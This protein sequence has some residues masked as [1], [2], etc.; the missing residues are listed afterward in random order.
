MTFAR[1]TPPAAL[2][3]EPRKALILIDCQNDFIDQ[4]QGKL[5][6]PGASTFVERLSDLATSFRSKGLVVF[7]QTEFRGARTSFSP[8]WGTYNILQQQHLP[9]DP[10][11]PEHGGTHRRGRSS[12]PIDPEAFLQASVPESQRACRPGTSGVALSQP[13]ADVYDPKCDLCITKSQYSAFKDTPLLLQLRMRMVQHLYVAGSLSNIGVYATVTDAVRHGLQVTLIEDCLGYRNE[14]CHVEAVKQMVDMMGASGVDQQELMD[15]LAGLLGDV[16][17]EEDLG[18]KFQ[19]NV[20]PPKPSGL[21]QPIS[22]T[23]LTPERKQQQVEEWLTDRDACQSKSAEIVPESH[24]IS[25]TLEVDPTVDYESYACEH[26]NMTQDYGTLAGSSSPQIRSSARSNTTANG[27]ES[28]RIPAR[29]SSST[30]TSSESARYKVSRPRIRGTRPLSGISVASSSTET[31]KTPNAI[32]EQ[33]MAAIAA[34]EGLGVKTIDASSTSKGVEPDGMDSTSRPRRRIHVDLDTLVKAIQRP[35]PSRKRKVKNS[36]VLIGPAERAGEG[37]CYIIGNIVGYAEADSA[38]HKLKRT[39]RWQKMFHRTGEVPRLV[40]VQG[41]VDETTGTEPVYRHPADESPEMA[42]FDDTV[43]TLR[44]VAEKHVGHS[45]N[46]VLIQYYRN[47]ED[48]IS[49][50]SDKTLDITRGSSI[51]N[52]SFGAQRVM[53]LRT[54]KPETPGPPSPTLSTSKGKEPLTDTHVHSSGNLKTLDEPLSPERTTQRIPLM[55]DSIFILGPRTN[56]YWLHSVRPDKRPDHE[57]V[58]EELAYAGERISL[59]FRSIATYVNRE[60]GTI[61]GQGARCK[62][63]PTQGHSNGYEDEENVSKQKGKRV[64]DDSTQSGTLLEGTEAEIQGEKMIKAFGQE[65]HRSSTWDWDQWYGE[66]FD[67]V[68]FETTP[69]AT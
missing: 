36:A 31:P 11:S 42:S 59:T 69:V 57:K 9:Q 54:K 48:N 26:S 64:A 8:E 4:V 49:E 44:R 41:A 66:G 27:G 60:R 43:N 3:P 20:A 23:P 37:D 40:A 22:R 16:I 21:A 65:N 61:W 32:R 29:R 63:P 67:V 14:R 52:F 10:S 56:Q 46:H 53:T 13:L 28:S 1:N 34:S 50:H 5:P 62:E 17:R 45:L 18:P 68:N 55:H 38:F 15:D 33:I 51:V 7:A 47:G 12:I 58:E 39:V 2:R 35:P 30:H 6:V 19:I 24:G 25:E